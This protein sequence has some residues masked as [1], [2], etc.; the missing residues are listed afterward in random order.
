MTGSKMILKKKAV[1]TV[2]M[3]FM[4][5]GICRGE[6]IL[7]SSDESKKEFSAQVA[8][9]IEK[10]W[11][12]WQDEV[13]IGNIEVNGGRGRMFPGGLGGGVLTGGRIMAG[14]GEKNIPDEIFRCFSAVAGAIGDCMRVWQREYR[15][16]NIPFPEGS[17]SSFSLTPCINVPVSVSSGF[18]AGERKISESA[19][20]DHMLYMGPRSGK[21]VSA[22][23]KATARAFRLVFEEWKNNCFIEGI[24]ASGGVA[25]APAPMGTG[26][27]PVR[28]AR[29]EGGKLTGAYFDG[30]RMYD[31]MA[32]A[33]LDA[34]GTGEK[35]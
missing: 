30:K 2:V 6:D 33:L 26:P 16:D 29:G 4:C 9:L 20:Y 3:L 24:T 34:P 31:E 18:S 35:M 10:A 27:G 19:L 5:H 22:V 7:F 17:S 28:G 25:P 1:L 11:M 21:E 15:N 14:L 23:F 13:V 12:A 8:D 32:G